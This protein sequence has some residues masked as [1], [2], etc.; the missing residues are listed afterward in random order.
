MKAPLRIVL[1]QLA[2]LPLSALAQPAVIS[3]TS[4]T[5]ATEDQKLRPLKF[6]FGIGMAQS[7]DIGPYNDLIL[8]L[9]PSY[10]FSRALSLS[11]RAQMANIDRQHLVQHS[12]SYT[13]NGQFYFTHTKV[14]PFAGAGL[15][16]YHL[17]D[18]KYESFGASGMIFSIID[19]PTENRF[20]LYPQLGVE[21]G[22]VKLS[23]EYEFIPKTGIPYEKVKIRNDYLGITLSAFILAG[24]K[25]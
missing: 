20:G 12:F 5:V 18:T 7:Y 1:F 2:L 19:V 8:Y 9:Q 3:N 15:G 11:F 10:R 6:E 25:R 21:T 22:P 14:R 16:L 23:V 17:P 4:E 24:P 13:I